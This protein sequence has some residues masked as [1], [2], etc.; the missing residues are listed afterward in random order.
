VEPGRGEKSWR[1]GGGDSGRGEKVRDVVA[2]A[3]G[4]GQPW[5]G[6]RRE[7]GGR[8]CGGVGIHTGSHGVRMWAGVG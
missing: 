8:W 6:G 5:G 1:R 4:A 2:D 3:H 7:D